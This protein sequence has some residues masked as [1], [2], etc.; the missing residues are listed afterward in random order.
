MDAESDGIVNDFGM[1]LNATGNVLVGMGQIGGPDIFYASRSGFNDGIGHIVVWRRDRFGGFSYLYVDGVLQSQAAGNTQS[2]TANA[3]VT[4]GAID[5]GYNIFNG[6]IPE[7]VIYN[8]V[9]SIMDMEGLECYLSKIFPHELM[10]F[11]ERI[12]FHQLFFQS[13]IWLILA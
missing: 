4:I 5:S 9:V 11:T 8:T 12:L 6:R 2:L 10:P 7:I 1:A 3:I 13:V